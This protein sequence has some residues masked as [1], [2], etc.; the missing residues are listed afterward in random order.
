LRLRFK[1]HT[2]I[3]NYLEKPRG[4]FLNEHALSSFKNAV[5]WILKDVRY[6]TISLLK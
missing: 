6:I 3:A 2:A 5:D 1:S 4:K